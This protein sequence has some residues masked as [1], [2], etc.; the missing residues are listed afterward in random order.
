MDS[1]TQTLM[2][3]L[4]DVQGETRLNSLREL[5]T[6]VRAGTMGAP[7]RGDDVNNHIH[8][9]YSFSPYSPSAAIWGAY[10]A[11]LRSA[12]IMDHDS[13]AGAKE[14][15]DAGAAAGVATTIGVECRTDFSD[16]P[17]RGRRINNPDQLSNAYIALHGIPHTQIEA[18]TKYFAP[19][20]AARQLRNVRMVERINGLVPFSNGPLSYEKHVL[21][22]SRHSEGG[23]VT[24][25]H[26][27]WGM[28]HLLVEEFG[29]GEE[30]LRFVAQTLGVTVPQKIHHRL[31]DNGNSFFEYDLLGILKS[32]FVGKFY[33]EATDECP[34]IRDVVGFAR[35]CNCICA[36][37]Y[38]GDVADSVTGDKK[39]RKYE[40]D[41]LD[42][43]MAL[44]GK[45]GFQA[46]TYMPSRNT[47]AQLRRIMDL[48]GR[49][50]F[51]EISGEDI[52][53]PRQS[54]VCTAMRRPEFGHLADATWALIGHEKAATEDPGKG[55]F[56]VE[57][58]KKYPDL[59][60]R[61]HYFKSIGLQK[62][63]S[64][65]AS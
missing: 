42:E 33:V 4:S 65:K 10:R 44:L 41:F 46:V 64:A 23:T 45:L 29:K 9:T 30:L 40:D 60:E 58:V 27:L 25:R 57:S 35:K 15:I 47:P 1:H 21:P 12:G 5:I 24:E 22:F 26:I 48:C 38:L 2:D 55:F 36:Y 3:G 19:Y 61:I 53:S 31:L 51:L 34:P 56:S 43:L 8:T 52:N 7:L 63:R 54:F 13:I 39:A 62:E 20:I 37:A 11:G 17:L 16:T 49:H 59:K 14:F 6:G 50:G 18:V 32:E 28:I